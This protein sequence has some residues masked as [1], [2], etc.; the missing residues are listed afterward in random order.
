VGQVTDLEAAGLLEAA[1]DAMV[2][3]AA[4]GQIV[5]VNAQAER[6]FGYQRAELLGEPVEIL[7][8]DAARAMH[9]ALRAGYDGAPR[10]MGAGTELSGRRRDGTMFPAE[11]SLS[12]I[13]TGQGRLVTA[14]VRDITGRLALEA[15][16]D[17]LRTRA[18][19]DR[20]DGL[21]QLAGGVAHNFNNVLG[22]ISSYAAFIGETAASEPAQADWPAIRRDTQQITQAARRAAE[23]TG[24]LLTFGGRQVAE[25]R[26]LDLNDVIASTRPR[27][28]DVLGG[29]AELH[30]HLAGGLCPVLAD[31][32][33][34]EQVLLSL[35]SNA[36]EAMPDGGTLTISTAIRDIDAP[37]E[38]ARAG[39][40]LG[41]YASLTIHDTGTGMLPGVAARAFE[42]FFTTK[43]AGA[44]PGLGLGLPTVY[45][46]IAQADGQV[47]IHSEPGSGT[48]VA[49]L[50]PAATPVT[51]HPQP[52][53]GSQTVLVAEDE[54]ALREVT[55]RMLARN[56]YQVITA[57]GGPQ[58]VRAAAAHPGRI[59]LLLTD[60]IMP[61]LDGRATADQ[62]RAFQP[63]A[64]VVY[65]SGYTQGTLGGQGI[66]EAGA[67]LIQKP[68]TEADLL[69]KVREVLTPA[70]TVPS[71]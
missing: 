70:G 58:A 33:Q 62:V 24:Q 6:L 53:G 39:L 26:L 68:F 50:L 37:Y 9:P 34:I 8:P 66:I 16:R 14:A 59:D 36:R 4:G 12:A 67:H 61:Q 2:C 45:G 31:A 63:A 71:G 27:L 3:V 17:R 69:A 22:I 21:G 28:A 23:L 57:A 38:A 54:P 1:P 64:R 35:A 25:L 60:V 20:L 43:A 42:P 13:D 46:I 30:T 56:G 11:I 19:R 65:M 5:L 48:T 52:Q 51:P 49:I 41:R 15:E 29:H 7:V 55:R 47:Q 10:P 18:E 32:Q 40:A 44:G